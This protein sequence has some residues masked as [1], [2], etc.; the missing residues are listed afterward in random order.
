[1]HARQ[2]IGRV[3]DKTGSLILGPLL[4]LSQTAWA[5]FGQLNMTPGVTST[6][7][8]VFDLHMLIFWICLGIALL[9][10]GV[11]GFSILRHRKSRGAV[12][13]R[14]SGNFKLEIAWTLVAMMILAPWRRRHG[15]WST[16]TKPAIRI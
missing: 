11:M 15:Y 8:M 16:W 7:R 5:D 3:L 14:F 1:M 6:S 13:S 4:C 9:V 10:F 2:R 12:A